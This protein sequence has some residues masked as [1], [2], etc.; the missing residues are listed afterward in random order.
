MM[1]CADPSVVHRHSPMLRG[2]PAPHWQRR[3][4]D[5][6]P[7]SQEHYRVCSYCGSM[8]PE[9][10]RNLIAGG[11]TTIQ[12]TTKA[13]KRYIMTPN[14]IAGREVRI[15][16][17]SGPIVHV[18]GEPQGA[19]ARLLAPIDRERSGVPEGHRI[20]LLQRLRGTWEHD[21]LGTAPRMIQQKFYMEHVTREEW[22]EIVRPLVEA[23]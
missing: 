2:I 4:W 23:K 22:D 20:G 17:R 12:G 18:G 8:H 9:D 11:S 10:L 1:N 13:Y 5:G 7:Y 21:M 6:G 14:P 16:S 19:V 15:G 3:G